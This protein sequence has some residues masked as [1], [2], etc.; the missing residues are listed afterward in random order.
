MNGANAADA[1]MLNV[2]SVDKSKS[3]ILIFKFLSI[4]ARTILSFK[5]FTFIE[6][7]NGRNIS[8]MII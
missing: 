1:G 5:G 7:K 2:E 8:T 3:L 6:I 4:H